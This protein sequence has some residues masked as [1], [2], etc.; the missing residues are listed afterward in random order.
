[1]VQILKDF[2]VKFQLLQGRKSVYRPGWDC[3]GLPIELKASCTKLMTS[4]AFLYRHGLQG[5]T[6]SRLPVMLAAVNTALD[7]A[8]AAQ[9]QHR[10]CQHDCLYSRSGHD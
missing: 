6:A 3:H 2:I 9:L 10:R 4:D 5:D 1:M 8:S 7:L